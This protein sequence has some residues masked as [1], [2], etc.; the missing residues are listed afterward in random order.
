MAT[1]TPQ[2]AGPFKRTKIIIVIRQLI[3]GGAES[4][5]YEL[6][7]RLDRRIFD[8]TVCSLQKDGYFA[9][10]LEKDHIPVR[11]IEK[12]SKYDISIIPRL[13]R[14]FSQEKPDIV[15][16]VMWTANMWG[17]L[18]ANLYRRARLVVSTRSIGTWKKREHFFL[19]PY[20]FNRADL[21]LANSG[22][23]KKFMVTKERIRADKI[24]V[25]PNGIDLS[26]FIE[27]GPH[28]DAKWWRKEL[29]LPAEGHL[30]GTVANLSPQKDL[31]TFIRAIARIGDLSKQASFLI[32][33][34]GP[35]R[36]RLE[37]EA[38]KLGVLGR[39]LFVGQKVDV[40]PYLRS[41]DLFVLSSNR[42]GSSNALL[43]AMA[44]GLPVIATRVGG[45]IEAVKE[46]VT[47]YFY[48][49]GDDREL[50]R[51]M[52]LLLSDPGLGRELGRAGK[53]RV[54][55]DFDMLKYISRM[56]T[57]YCSLLGRTDPLR[58]VPPR[59]FSSGGR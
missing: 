28:H 31:S 46:G 45:N 56:E 13:V 37:D 15:H 51:L 35:L 25:V 52:I 43:E 58:S 2:E 47:G 6:A 32:V 48:D 16:C 8:V 39:M 40:V 11:I 27:N 29:G 7:R 24:Q 9:S 42:E 18:S 12:H 38:R 33:G 53:E 59:F 22:E 41:L 36:G 1:V 26:R 20:V 34:D 21:I 55:R 30:A 49:V 23:V 57:V 17:G 19:G 50:A 14:F 5:T 4:Q 44:T 3:I 10:L 54:S